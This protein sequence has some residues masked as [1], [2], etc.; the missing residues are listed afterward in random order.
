[1]AFY[2]SRYDNHVIHD[3]NNHIS[4][5]EVLLA[6]KDTLLSVDG[7]ITLVTSSPNPSPLAA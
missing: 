5:L 7:N 4:L 6:R 2:H 1:M 3:L